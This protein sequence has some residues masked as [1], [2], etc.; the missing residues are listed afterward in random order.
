MLQQLSSGWTLPSEKIE[1]LTLLEGEI[2]QRL[3]MLSETISKGAV[4]RV[5]CA[6]EVKIAQTNFDAANEKQRACSADLPAPNQS[7][8]SMLLS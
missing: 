2:C 3:A 1:N 8:M 6:A 7:G 4:A 5:A